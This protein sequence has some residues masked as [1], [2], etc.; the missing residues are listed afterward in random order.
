[1]ILI[2]ATTR[3]K[4]EGAITIHQELE[5][6]H[7]F[8]TPAGFDPLA[9]RCIFV[10]T[11]I[12]LCSASLHSLTCESLSP[13]SPSLFPHG[14]LE[15]TLPATLSHLLLVPSPTYRWPCCKCRRQGSW[16]SRKEDAKRGRWKRWPCPY[17]R[18]LDNS[19][20]DMTLP[21]WSSPSQSPH[22]ASH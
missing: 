20:P 10:W 7:L 14:T 19:K 5:I 18:R 1:M 15:L 4:S 3:L 2:N 22:L 17:G 6:C 8:C 16:A 9:N 13:L 12:L 21:R 11:R